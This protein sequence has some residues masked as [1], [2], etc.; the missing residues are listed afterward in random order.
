[1][2]KKSKLNRKKYSWVEGKKRMH[3]VVFKT[4][5][6]NIFFKGWSENIKRKYKRK[7]KR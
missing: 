3:V 4:K 6:D 5:N 2:K 1:M 7:K